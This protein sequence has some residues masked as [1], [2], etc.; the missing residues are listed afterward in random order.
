VGNFATML[1]GTERFMDA[2]RRL[3]L[4]GLT[5]HELPAR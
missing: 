5:F 4:D 1:I 2:V 3:E